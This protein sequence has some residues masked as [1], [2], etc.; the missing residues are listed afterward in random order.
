MDFLD[1]LHLFR[2]IVKEERR[3]TKDYHRQSLNRYG[4]STLYNWWK[5]GSYLWFAKRYGKLLEETGRNISFCSVFGKRDVLEKVDGLRVFFSGENVHNSPYDEYSDYLLKDKTTSLGLGFEC[6]ENERYRR[7]PLW[8]LY[9]FDPESTY[10]DVVVRCNELRYPEI[11]EK[12][13]FC[14][15]VASHD[16]NGLRKVMVTRLNGVSPVSCAGRYLHN[17]DSLKKDY[18]DDKIAYLKAFY[19]NICPENSNSWGYVT[20]KVFEAI[21][22]GCIPVYWGSYNKPEQGILNEDA[23]LFWQM[24]QDNQNLI[25]RV[26]HLYTSPAEMDDFLHQPRLMEGAEDFVWEMIEGL[27]SAISRLIKG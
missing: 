13:R 26:S 27:D 16:W 3:T 12:T 18:S 24:D 21:D 10:K 22:A 19:F 20:E 8:I 11:S 14:S 2:H 1:S 4:N 7:F 6:F 5:S 25:D 15:M 23:I 17:D 9:M